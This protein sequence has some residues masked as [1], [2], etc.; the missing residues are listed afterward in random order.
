MDDIDVDSEDADAAGSAPATADRTR[1]SVPELVVAGSV[2]AS[3]GLFLGFALAGI[4]IGVRTHQSGYDPSGL[5]ITYG[6]EWID[7]TVPL[8]LLAVLAAWWGQAGWTTLSDSTVEVTRWRLRPYLVAVAALAPLTAAAGIAR[9]ADT[10]A[11]FS[12][13]GS[14]RDAMLAASAGICVMALAAGIAEWMAASRL[15]QPAEP[16]ATSDT[17]TR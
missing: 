9:L 12:T 11:N 4:D 17:P 16:T 2:V 6:T 8:T 3:V 1:W 7:F 13:G 15:L 10:L 5:A 14:T